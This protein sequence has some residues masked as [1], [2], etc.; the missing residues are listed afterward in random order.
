MDG[1]LLRHGTILEPDNRRT[2]ATREK[3]DLVD[4]IRHSSQKGP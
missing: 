4:R 1:A 2:D 3:R